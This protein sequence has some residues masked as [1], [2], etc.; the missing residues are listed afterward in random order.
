MDK[1]KVGIVGTGFTIGI[2]KPHLE[3]YL[4]NKYVDSIVLFDSIKGRAQEWIKEKG[5][6]DKRIVICDSYEDLLKQVD[7]VS[8]CT[9]N[10]THK[11]LSIKALESGKHVLC[12]KPISVSA[13]EAKEMVN[14]ARNHNNLVA[15]TGFC[16]RGIPAVK[17]MKMMIESGKLGKIFGCTHQLG[18]GRIANPK[19]V[20]LEWRMEEEKSGSG[21]LADFGSHML[22]LTEYVLSSSEGPIKSLV[23]QVTT[24]IHER[25]CINQ[26]GSGLVTNDDT[27]AFVAKL[28]NGAVSTFFSTRLGLSKH[29]W[30]ITGEGGILVYYGEDDKIEILLKDKEGSYEFGQ[31]PE[32]V[33]VPD[34]MKNKGRFF[35]EIDYFIDCIRENKQPDR[36]FERGLYI[37][38]MLELLKESSEDGKVKVL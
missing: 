8:I 35:D 7:A 37:Q 34:A 12:E 30:E 27:A 4:E 6:T 17:Y 20:K 21:A 1:V 2:A 16:Y 3:A 28:E 22:D 18:G 29:R 23:A 15:M 38:N 33:E 10:N 32:V 14:V 25:Q 5:Y 13:K 9:P 36:N 31:K 26:D 24:S 19:D 11:E